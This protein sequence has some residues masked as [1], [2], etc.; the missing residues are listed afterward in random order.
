MQVNKTATP[1]R[2]QDAEV[3]GFTGANDFNTDSFAMETFSGDWILYC[4]STHTTGT[5]KVTIQISDEGDDG[6]P[7][8]FT[9]KDMVDIP[10]TQSFIDDEVFPKFMRIVYTANS[11]D[12][13]V[14][15]KLSRLI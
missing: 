9:Y 15:F 1:F 10:I 8:W 14:T 11:S 12:G 5:P 2:V 7:I 6:S 4:S 13:L 3:V